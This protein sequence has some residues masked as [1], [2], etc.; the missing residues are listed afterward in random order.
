[1]LRTMRRLA[2]ALLIIMAAAPAAAKELWEFPWTE[3]RTPHFVFLSGLDEDRTTELAVDLE[4]FR[5][6][7]QLLTNIGRF[8]ERIPTRIVVLPRFEDELGFGRGI[9]G[10]FS[11]GMRDNAAVMLPSG[12]FSDEVLK[13]EY[14]HFLVHNRNQQMYPPWFDEGFAE[15]LMTLTVKDGVLTYGRPITARTSWLAQGNWISFRR[16]LE[17]RST[18][19]LRRDELGMFYAQAWFL[20]HYL[21]IGREGVSFAEQSA[22]FA[23]SVE[24]GVP[25]LEAFESAFGEK[26]DRLRAQLEKYARRGRFYR[27][28]LKKPFP[29]V[30]TKARALP[31]DE[32]A[33][34]L[35]L[36]VLRRGDHEAA[37]KYF[38]AA[39][40]QN[41]ANADALVGAGDVHKF[42]GR[43][44]EAP[45]YYEK[46][47]AAEPN[48]ANHELD[49]AE[50]FLDLAREAKDETARAEALVEARRHFA[51]SY[52][53]N[54]DNPETLA[55][56]GAT[57]LF[58][59]EQASKAVE[60]LEVAH[61]LLP[62][63]PQIRALLAEA[64][65]RADQKDKARRHLDQLLAWSHEGAVDELRAR[66]A[67]LGVE[68][69][70]GDA[71]GGDAAPA[72]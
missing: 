11:P 34:A 38:D 33:S 27:M 12:S 28:A 16:V 62:S 58:E 7:A 2:P 59:G 25:P 6:A 42:T 44:A 64:Y 32:V 8:E 3:V 56:N 22:A 53:L 49:Y 13:H 71:P 4:N 68:T 47:I 36:L 50:Y 20:V 35:G 10:Y 57:Y 41:P 45:P 29:P 21:M 26:P 39:L 24:S 55:M 52:K 37:S 19:A 23:K 31:A 1:M 9:A 43:F 14:V 54:P 61:S 63:Q 65:A 69:A 15:V 66:L 40:A 46:A 72:E 18:G 67:K 60:S 30:E 17:A 48:E 70:E 51:R 5:T